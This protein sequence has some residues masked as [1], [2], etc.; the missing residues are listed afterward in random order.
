MEDEYSFHLASTAIHCIFTV[1]SKYPN[2][3]CL[4]CTKI[5]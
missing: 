5:Q 2:S 4:H 3:K 1:I